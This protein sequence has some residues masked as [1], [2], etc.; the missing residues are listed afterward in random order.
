MSIETGKKA[1]KN[2]IKVEKAEVKQTVDLKTGEI[3]TVSVRLPGQ[4][5]EILFDAKLPLFQFE[6][7]QLLVKQGK[8]TATISIVNYLSKV[9]LYYGFFLTCNTEPLEEKIK[10]VLDAKAQYEAKDQPELLPDVRRDELKRYDSQVRDLKVQMS[11]LIAD[12]PDLDF[13]AKVNKVDDTGDNI[14]LEL[15]I[16][17]EA[18]QKLDGIWDKV[19]NYKIQLQHKTF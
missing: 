4:K 17:S 7:N 3:K 8:R 1:K 9:F 2:E 11:E 13:H 14:K 16:D 6:L 18:L 19:S 5:P 15:A 10:A 12:H